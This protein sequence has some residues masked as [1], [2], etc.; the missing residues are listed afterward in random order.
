MQPTEKPTTPETTPEASKMVIKQPENLP[1]VSN[2]HEIVTKSP[3]SLDKATN[4][5]TYIRNKRAHT[6]FKRYVAKGKYTTAQAAALA[7]GVDPSTI[8]TWL[9]TKTIIDIMSS[10]VDAYI[11][12]IASAQDWKA[13]QYLLER[14]SPTM[15]EE[16]AINNAIQIVLPVLQDT[17]GQ[18]MAL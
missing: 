12:K 1:T 14:V 10:E 17:N 6:A 3:T 16:R 8:R 13:Q 15:K 2:T 18:N 4:E 11:D 7:C 5:L 9:S